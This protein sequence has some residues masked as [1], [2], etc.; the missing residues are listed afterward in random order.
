MGH[1]TFGWLRANYYGQSGETYKY[2]GR[3]GRI[4]M[5]TGI[6]YADEVW[7]PIIG[8]TKIKSGCKNCWAERLHNQ[9][10]SA[11]AIGRWPDAPK[12][13]HKAFGNVELLPDRLK[14][15]LHWRKPRTIFV[16]SM[17]DIF[18]KDVPFEFI[19]RILAIAPQRPEHTFLL[20]T[21]RCRRASEYFAQHTRNFWKGLIDNVHLY[22]S[23]S[24]QAEME[25][26]MEYLLPIPV[27][28]RG[29]SFE[30]LVEDIVFR[31]FNQ[32]HRIQSVI[33]GCESGP[34]RRPCKLGG[35]ESIVDQ[36]KDAGVP[37]YVKQIDTSEF[38]AG[39][40]HPGDKFFTGNKVSANPRDWPPRFRVREM[41]K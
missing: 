33:V 6:P 20:F 9:R 14:Q 16:C 2:N 15:P 22:F 34:K 3:A 12:Q 27:V 7:S 28:V 4:T 19:D 13:Y 31:G 40:V 41:P 18:H 39:G 10:H 25:E 23:A 30:P 11:W 38:K 21:K 1:R 26:A 37:V 8:C 36:C 17:S 29:F 5:A 32:L 24:N 35:I